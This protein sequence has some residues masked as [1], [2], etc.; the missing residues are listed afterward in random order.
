MRSGRAWTSVTW[1]AQLG[2]ELQFLSLQT[3]S[4]CLA[5]SRGSDSGQSISKECRSWMWAIFWKVLLI[6]V[7]QWPLKCNHYLC[8][9]RQDLKCS[10]SLQ[11][12]SSFCNFWYFLTFTW[13]WTKAP[14][15]RHSLGLAL[16]A[17]RRSCRAIRLDGELMG[18]PHRP[19]SCSFSYLL[20]YILSVWSRPPESLVPF[21]RYE[22]IIED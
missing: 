16:R 5:P 9:V 8:W 3:K 10:V 22:L 13:T 2:P 12:Y 11:K 19:G 18:L 17:G 15:R 14:C 1:R 4:L 21:S 20:T 6:T 7:S